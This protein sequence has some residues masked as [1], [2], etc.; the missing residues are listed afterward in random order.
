M[1]L[2]RIKRLVMR[3]GGDGSFQLWQSAVFTVFTIVFLAHILACFWYL[4]GINSEQLGTGTGVRGWVEQQDAWEV[5]LLDANW[6]DVSDRVLVVNPSISVSVRYLAS[7]CY[8]LN[9]LENAYT[10]LEMGFSVFA[11]LV[12]D[13]ILGLV[14]SLITTISISISSTDTETEIRL[15]RLRSWMAEKK[16]PKAFRKQALEHFTDIWT[17]NY[18]HMPSLLTECPPAM[19]SKMA[20]LLYGRYVATVP[21]FKGLSQEVLSALCLKCQ[22]MSCMKNQNIIQEREPGREMCTYCSLNTYGP[23][24]TLDPPA[25]QHTDLR[26]AYLRLPCRHGAER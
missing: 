18:M 10:S 8:S 4:V 3:Y 24:P 20:V 14:A 12:R 19:A 21:L 13:V 23:N 11:E 2:A 1:R 22:P 5:S 25:S 6:T 26:M 17:T 16:L 9:A 7:M 15:R